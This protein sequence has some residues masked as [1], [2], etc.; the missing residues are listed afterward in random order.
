M[1]TSWKLLQTTLAGV[2][3]TSMACTGGQKNTAAPTVP[4]AG[5]MAEPPAKPEPV[6]KPQP[7]PEPPKLENIPA[8]AFPDE[9]FRKS[10]PAAGKA[11]NFKFPKI[12]RF[13]LRNGVTVYLVEK[14]NLPIVSMDLNFDG[15]SIN[16]PKGKEGLASMCMSLMTDG[17]KKLDK[18]AFNEAL[19][20]TAS[21]IRSYATAEQQ[22]LN[23]S[24]LSKNFDSTFALFVDTLTNPGFREG[25]FDRKKKRS[26]ARLSQVR[27]SPRAVA[28]RVVDK[29]LYGPKHPFG[30]IYDEKSLQALSTADCV[31]YHKA[32]LKPR[33]ARLFV[34]GDITAKQI[35]AAFANASLKGWK[36]RPKR[37]ARL[38]RPRTVKGKIFFVNIPGAAQSAIYVRHFGP[39]RKA[40]GYFP[41]MLAG[42]ILGGGFSG[43]VNMNL[44]EDKGYSYGARA[45][46]S[47][48]RNY[49]ELSA[50]TSVRSDST[51]QSVLEIYNEMKNLKTGKKPATAEELE[52]EKNGAILGLPARFSSARSALG[53]Y[54]SLVYYRL[55]LNYYN[56]YVRNIRRVTL[57][58]VNAA[59]KRQ[60][61]PNRAFYL[62]VGDAN[63]P[64]KK[65]VD[66]DKPGEKGKDVPLLD[67]K[68]QPMTL[69]GSLRQLAAKNALGKGDLVVLDADGNPAKEAGEASASK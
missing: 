17:T 37:S 5:P 45:N 56:R 8:L 35:R 52:R 25:D 26:L 14:H 44:R 51:Y 67:D 62:V 38:R 23:M 9:A 68:G 47:Y 49:G 4:P 7:K 59:A 30:R 18:I 27:A 19:A 57:A 43:R 40:R 65:H 55:P 15:G 46:F 39:K 31:K 41:N 2:L 33:G 64:Q 69:L 48:S 53:Q 42:M 12:N 28:G 29:L 34:V 32:Y 1:M 66:S 6:A 54:R 10:A 13:R 60:L 22:G 11:A 20:D 24:T 61:K 63:A 58:Q 21:S 50:G 3:V 16:D 36:G